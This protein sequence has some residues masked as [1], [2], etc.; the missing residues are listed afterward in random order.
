MK[1]TASGVTFSAAMTRSPSFSRSSSSTTMSIRPAA[2]SAM[3]SSIA[4]NGGCAPPAFIALTS[5]PRSRAACR[6]GLGAW[7]RTTG[8]SP[9][10]YRSTKRLHVLGHHVDF[11]VDRSA[12]RLVLERR[13]LLGHGAP[14]PPRSSRRGSARPSARCRRRR[15]SPWATMY[16]MS[17]ARHLELVDRRVA[18]RVAHAAACRRPRRDRSPCA[19]RAGPR[20]AARARG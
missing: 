7:C 18:R 20:A 15:P 1:L 5:R 11:D 16:S 17:A 19:R 9:P 4:E 14:P 8:H 2:I 13:D 3:P 10:A 6:R 12:D